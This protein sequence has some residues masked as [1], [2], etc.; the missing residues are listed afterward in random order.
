MTDELQRTATALRWAAE[1]LPLSTHT[2]P[3]SVLAHRRPVKLPRNVATIAA[4][5]RSRRATGA[6]DVGF[7]AGLI[8]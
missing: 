5:G 1:K 6:R 8:E 3:S 2:R 4:A 7:S